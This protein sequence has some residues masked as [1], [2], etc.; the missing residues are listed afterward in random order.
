M[1]PRGLPIVFQHPVPHEVFARPAV[2]AILEAA[3]MTAPRLEGDVVYVTS[4]YRARLPDDPFSYHSFDAYPT[5]ASV[6][7][8]AIDIR[9]VDE[10]M[11]DG[12]IM[13]ASRGAQIS[14]GYAWADRIRARLWSTYDV[15]FGDPRHIDH[16]HVE[17]DGRKAAAVYSV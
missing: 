5:G 13:G 1:I 14:A 12:A 17:L 8:C 11:R 3:A 9:A 4:T 10:H 16:M 2:Q 6:A 15:V 7:G